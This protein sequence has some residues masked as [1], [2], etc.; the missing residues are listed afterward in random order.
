M[1][2]GDPVD[3]STNHGSATAAISDPVVEMTSALKSATNA[4]RFTAATTAEVYV[5][6]CRG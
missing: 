4:R 2:A 5:R 3:T 6:W 1:R